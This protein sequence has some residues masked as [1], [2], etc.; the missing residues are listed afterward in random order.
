MFILESIGT[1]VEL[2]TRLDHAASA[3]NTSK[4][5]VDCF[6][7]PVFIM[8]LYVRAEREGDWPLHLVAVMMLLFFFASS[9]VNYTRYG[10]YYLRSGK[11]RARRALK[12]HERRA[13]DTPCSRAME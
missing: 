11:L 13:R 2:L 4:L 8:M 7:N 12:V 1:M 10:L 9:H 3:S 5:W 6:I